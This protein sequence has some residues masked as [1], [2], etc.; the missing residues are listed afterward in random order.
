MCILNSCVQRMC[1]HAFSGYVTRIPLSCRRVQQTRH[2]HPLGL[3]GITRVRRD[4]MTVRRSVGVITPTTRQNH[5]TAYHSVSSA[6]VSTSHAAHRVTRDFPCVLEATATAKSAA[7]HP[8]RLSSPLRL[9]VRCCATTTQNARILCLVT[10]AIL[11]WWYNHIAAH[12][13]ARALR[14]RRRTFLR[15]CRLQQLRRVLGQ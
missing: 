7:R 15:H 5:R 2:G 8:Q 6:G 9:G 11:R 14:L 1:F 4:W 12:S 3:V 10:H 13:D